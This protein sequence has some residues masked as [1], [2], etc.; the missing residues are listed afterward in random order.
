MRHS[1]IHNIAFLIVLQLVCISTVFSLTSSDFN[2]C[3]SC[4]S[5]LN[6]LI[7]F[8]HVIWIQNYFKHS[9][10]FFH[11]LNQEL[12][13]SKHIVCPRH[14]SRLWS[15]GGN[16]SHRQDWASPECG[17]ETTREKG[18]ALHWGLCLWEVWRS[19]I[20]QTAWKGT[21]ILAGV[22][23]GELVF[24]NPNC[25]LLISSVRGCRVGDLGSA[26]RSLLKPINVVAEEEW[27]RGPSGAGVRENS[28][29][30]WESWTP[31]T[32]TET[33][34]HPRREL[35]QVAGPNLLYK[36]STVFLERKQEIRR[37][38]RKGTPTTLD[39]EE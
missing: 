24:P 17:W 16:S 26:V 19:W 36:P 35:E 6:H 23:L 28:R 8:K 14:C 13:N 34:M 2:S 20:Q 30:G 25:Q 39:K 29:C 18:Q 31:Q 10:K 7:I 38:N 27:P 4:C 37:N 11:V 5:P 9:E 21:A 15:V 1:F 12:C 33:L 3:T 32:S 22:K